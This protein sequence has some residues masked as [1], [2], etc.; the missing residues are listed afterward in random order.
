MKKLLAVAM[1]LLLNSSIFANEIQIVEEA[2]LEEKVVE[3]RITF[4]P[5]PTAEVKKQRKLMMKTKTGQALCSGSFISP[6]GHI[7]TARHCVQGSTEIEVLTYDQQE[8]KANIVAV[9]EKQDLAVI[10]I[11]KIPSPHFNIGR[12]LTKGQRIA[13]I[14]S[15]LG[16]TNLV[17]EGIVAKLYGDLTLLDCTALP[18]NSGGPVLDAEGNLVGVVSAMVVVLFGPAH[19]SVVQSVNSIVF[20]FYELQTG[21]YSGRK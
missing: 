3:L 16:L 19:I 14:G 9:S 10:Q 21:K 20:F 5:P 2:P 11:G 12:P 8:Y 13:I 18:G 7:L 15:P 1:S 6:Y 4:A 17:T